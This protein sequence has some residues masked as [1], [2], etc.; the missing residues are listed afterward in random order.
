MRLAADALSRAT[1]VAVA[2]WP[3]AFSVGVTSTRAETLEK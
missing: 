1:M 2:P 3:V